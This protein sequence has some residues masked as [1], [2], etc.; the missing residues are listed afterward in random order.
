L[1]LPDRFILAA[2]KSG[3]IKPIGKWALH[4]AC[5]EA[6]K[7]PPGIKVAVNVSPMQL[8][9]PAFLENVASAIMAAKV[10]PDRLQIEITES[11]LLQDTDDTLH[12][13]AKLKDI[14]VG[15]SVDD[16]GTG[17]SSLSY[18]RK[19]PF[20]TLKI[21]QSFTRDIALNIEARAIVE[22]TLNLAHKLGMTTVAEGVETTEQLKLLRSMHCSRVQGYLINRPL[23]ASHVPA[24][25]S[26]ARIEAKDLL[27]LSQLA[28]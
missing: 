22:S 6:M 20:D 16:F 24:M 27:I 9:D 8:R 21:D 12:V 3:A 23:P 28:A 17:Y 15:I 1:I 5:L 26:K 2:E 4:C 25:L 19:F 13:L 14:G 18:L 7:W 10:T 11:M